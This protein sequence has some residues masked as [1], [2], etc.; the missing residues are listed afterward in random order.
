MYKVVQDEL[1]LTDHGC[2]ETLIRHQKVSASGPRLQQAWEVYN[3]SNQD[4]AID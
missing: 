1:P 4:I 3:D 2:N